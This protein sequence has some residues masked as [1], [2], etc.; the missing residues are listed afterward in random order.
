MIGAVH[1]PGHLHA[2]S[3]ASGAT[4]LLNARSGRWHV[5]NPVATALWRELGRVGDVERVLDAAAN[6]YPRPTSEFFRLDARRAVEDMAARGLVAAGRGAAQDRSPGREHPSGLLTTEHVRATPGIRAH[7]GLLIALVLLRLPFHL[8]LR[9]VAALTSRWC[10]RT[11][12][13]DEVVSAVAEVDAVADRHLGRAACLERSL[14]TVIAAALARRRLRWVFGAAEDP[15]RFHAWIE[16][17]GI[18][19]GRTPEWA[20][21][22]FVKVLAL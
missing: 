5:L 16:C 20:A 18:M 21:T 13:V 7:A 10:S 9:A 8:T 14:A 22:G 12:T 3:T 11:A 2:A 4:F 15:C 17:D 1:V 19:V 6:R